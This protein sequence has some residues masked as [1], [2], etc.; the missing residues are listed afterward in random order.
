MS[1]FVA[2]VPKKIELYVMNV[3]IIISKLEFGVSETELNL[4][5]GSV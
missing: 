5:S 4:L 2:V 3:F 1:F